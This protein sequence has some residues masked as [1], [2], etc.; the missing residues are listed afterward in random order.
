MLRLLVL[1]FQ[2][3]A[4]VFWRWALDFYLPVHHKDRRIKHQ[5]KIGL[6]STGVGC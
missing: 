3:C 6:R 2:N 5:F 4:S 1:E